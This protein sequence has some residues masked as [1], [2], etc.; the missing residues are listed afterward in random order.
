VS[1]KSPIR[2]GL[3]S[4][5]G[6]A[7]QPPDQQV[8]WQALVLGFEHRISRW[9][10]RH[11]HSYQ[12]AGL[13][14]ESPQNNMRRIGSRTPNESG[15]WFADVSCLRRAFLER[16]E[17]NPGS[18]RSC[19][20]MR[21]ALAD[22]STNGEIQSLLARAPSI[23]APCGVVTSLRGGVDPFVAVHSCSGRRD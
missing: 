6:S 9:R 2:Q 3:A 5:L 10:Q 8:Q 12:L 14:D 21:L 19:S 13:S 7:S 20:D 11:R 22:D 1:A 18:S 17:T 4:T 15:R 16:A 23:R